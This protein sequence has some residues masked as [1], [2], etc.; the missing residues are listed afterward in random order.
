MHLPPYLM[1]KF[2]KGENDG[3]AADYRHFDR[4]VK[5]KQEQ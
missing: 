4:D 5:D 2:L 3:I 1:I